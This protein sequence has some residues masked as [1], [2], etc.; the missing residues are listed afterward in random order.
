M[1]SFKTPGF[2]DADLE[3]IKV[4]RL[5][6]VPSTK[7]KTPNIVEPVS[8]DVSNLSKSAD[9]DLDSLT[10]TSLP[11]R[12]LENKITPHVFKSVSGSFVKTAGFSTTELESLD[13][14]N[15]PKIPP[16]H[17]ATSTLFEPA[18]MSVLTVDDIELMQKQAYDEAFAQGKKEGHS[19]GVT[20][21]FEEGFNDGINKGTAQGFEESLGILK[22]KA[23]EL[24]LLLEALSEPFK[25]FDTEVEQELIKIAISI[26][27][28]VIYREIKLDPELILAAVRAAIKALPLSAQKINLHLHP[29]DAELVRSSFEMDE[30]SSTWTILEDA[31]ITRGG[32][33][34]DTDISH[35]D[36][37]VEKR[38]SVVIATLLGGE[39]E[40][41]EEEEEQQEQEPDSDS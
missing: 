21:G 16:G 12:P 2:S 32:C 5:P 33:K 8:I 18:P 41:Q 36:V 37:S 15:L 24:N 6:E 34:V 17:K 31:S 4:W 9:A 30:S 10:E 23:A 35:V 13:L 26:A 28:Q 25:N 14:W 22:A 3:S 20:D 38:L 19:Q 39:K 1:T 29:A 7:I 27:T 11:D 40:Q